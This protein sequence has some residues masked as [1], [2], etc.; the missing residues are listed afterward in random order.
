M[1]NKVVLDAS[2]VLALINQEPG[3]EFVE[4]YLPSAIISTVNLSEVIAVLV[5]IGMNA[6]E[7]EAITHGL[8][9]EVVSFDHQQSII[10]GTLR[11]ETKKM[12][13]SLGDRACFALATVESLPVLTADKIWAKVNVGVEIKLIR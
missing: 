2:A 5:E 6:K 4:K 1:N 9:S 10:A 8:I 3:H 13:L 11:K 7:A 12:G